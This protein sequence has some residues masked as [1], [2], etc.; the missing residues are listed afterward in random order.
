[1]G[2]CCSTTCS[3]W[4]LWLQLKNWLSTLTWTTLRRMWTNHLF[5]TGRPSVVLLGEVDVFL[6]ALA[7]SAHRRVRRGAASFERVHPCLART[8]PH[9]PARRRAPAPQ[10]VRSAAASSMCRR[11]RSFMCDLNNR[12]LKDYLVETTLKN[13]QLILFFV[14]QCLETI[15]FQISNYKVKP[16]SLKTLKM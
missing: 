8:S 4:S 14:L 6:P 13:P 15:F 9:P 16:L 3:C 10:E 2:E 7:S 5:W 1:M 12:S 11:R